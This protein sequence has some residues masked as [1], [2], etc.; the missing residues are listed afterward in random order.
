MPP[1]STSCWRGTCTRA[2]SCSRRS[3][4]PTAMPSGSSRKRRNVDRKSESEST[5][6]TRPPT[7]GRERNER[8][9]SLPRARRPPLRRHLSRTGNEIDEHPED[10]EEEDEDEPSRLR[11]PAVICATEVVDERPEDHEQDEDEQ[12]EEGQRPEDAEEGVVV[13]E[14]GKL[15]ESVV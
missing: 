8:A 6:S 13:R 5:S 9:R 11:P 7:T 1:S 4:S 15:L 10:R 14:H 3:P 2:A 12:R